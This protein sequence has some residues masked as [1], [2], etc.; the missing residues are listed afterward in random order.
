MIIRNTSKRAPFGFKREEGKRALDSSGE[1]VPRLG[2]QKKV[3][4]SGISVAWSAWNLLRRETICYKDF[5]TE[6]SL[7]GLSGK[8]G[9][10]ADTHKQRNIQKA[11]AILMVRE[12]DDGKMRDLVTHFDR[13]LN[14]KAAD[15][16]AM[17]REEMDRHVIWDI[18]TQISMKELRQYLDA[19][20]GPQPGPAP[21]PA[22]ELSF[23]AVI[24][25][26]AEYM[27]GFSDFYP[28]FYT[29]RKKG[30][31]LA[32]R[33]RVRKVALLK[34]LTVSQLCDLLDYYGNRGAASD[35][36]SYGDLVRLAADTIPEKGISAYI[37]SRIRTS[38]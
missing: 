34:P 23:K 17:N 21:S 5:K 22:R 35:K 16:T 18:F 10:W 2:I 19:Q 12:L 29:A 30:E 4:G 37:T 11:K 8:S 3:K 14:L 20:A 32:E 7:S 25:G 24:R 13:I 28:S 15:A 6:Q 1:D 26:I 36:A 33:E 31:T 9:L 27:S 38:P